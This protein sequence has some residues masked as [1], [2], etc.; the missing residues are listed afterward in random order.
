MNKISKSAI[1]AVFF[2]VSIMV[3]IY[4]T[5]GSYVFAIEYNNYTSKTFGI[6]FQYPS[7]WKIDEFD[8]GLAFI[9]DRNFFLTINKVEQDVSGLQAL[10]EEMFKR[11]TDLGGHIIKIIEK[12]IMISTGNLEMGTFLTT[13]H[14][15]DEDEADAS[16]NQFWTFLANK[17][18][19]LITYGNPI[20]E[21]NSPENVE[22]LDHFIKSI[23]I[24]SASK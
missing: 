5:P 10:T 23:K 15:E 16:A 24:I 13:W 19:Y 11:Q 18:K 21:F 7:D 9:S 8:E 3:I 6:E 14:E 12:P 22:I 17:Q 20:A 1:L 2:I 4:F